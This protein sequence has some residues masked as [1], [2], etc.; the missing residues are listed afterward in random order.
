[1]PTAQQLYELW[2]DDAGLSEALGRSLQPRGRESL[3]EAFAALDPQPGE[4]VVDVGAR[5][6]RHTIRLVREHGLRAVA[7]DPVALHVERAR[8]E[9]TDAG[10]DV[11][12]VAGT[13][14]AL[15]LPDAHADWIWCRDVLVHADARRALAEFARVLRPGGTAIAYVTLATE[16][17]EPRERAELTTALG[18]AS[19]FDRTELEDAARDAGLRVRSI[20]VV[21]SEWRERMLEDGEWDAAADLLQ[22]ARLR[23]RRDELAAEHGADAVDAALGGALW[24]IYQLLGKLQPTI[25]V[26]ERGA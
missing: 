7:V 10:A 17:L 13:A 6:A 8:V 3:F 21:D 2:A 20:D 14:E 16:T 24:G 25:V 23:R 15:P 18:L 4:L 9:V 1:M 26:W 19:G 11:E 22:I 12:V 5:N